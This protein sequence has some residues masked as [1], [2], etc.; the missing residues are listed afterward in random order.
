[1]HQEEEAQCLIQ[2]SCELLEYVKTS[3]TLSQQ[4]DVSITLSTL[5]SLRQEYQRAIEVLGDIPAPK[6]RIDMLKSSIYVSSGAF[7]QSSKLNEALILELLMELR[8]CITLQT[9]IAYQKELYKDAIQLIKKVINIFD[10]FQV[11]MC[12]V[13]EYEYLVS[14][15]VKLQDD[16]QAEE[17]VLTYLT[18]LFV[19]HDK[20]DKQETTNS[21]IDK[22]E[23]IS[24]SIHRLRKKEE[25]QV[26]IQREQI[27]IA[28]ANALAKL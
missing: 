10:L 25:L 23:L 24:A 6:Y 2:I 3:G 17:A 13:T 7:D 14:C 19:E 18:M 27:Q 20:N 8:T 15:Y 28:I 21:I 26:L 1:M 22:K 9:V 16:D 12:F 5:Y 4:A 11:Q